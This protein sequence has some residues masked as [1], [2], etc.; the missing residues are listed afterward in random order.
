MHEMMLL[1]YVCV[2]LAALKNQ[3]KNVTTKQKRKRSCLNR[4][5]LDRSKSKKSFKVGVY[6]VGIPRRGHLAEVT[7][8]LLYILVRSEVS[9]QQEKW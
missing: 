1:Y 5:T 2:F 7:R 6:F 4:L 9:E 8:T 3:L